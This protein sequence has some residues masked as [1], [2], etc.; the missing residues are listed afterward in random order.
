[1]TYQYAKI[2]PPSIAEGITGTNAENK[3]CMF[4][5]GTYTASVT[6]TC[7]TP[8]GATCVIPNFTLARPYTLSTRIPFIF[9]IRTGGWT[10]NATQAIELF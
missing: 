1:M 7:F 4:L 5:Y 9:P 10:G 2:F 6:L 3:G 8:T